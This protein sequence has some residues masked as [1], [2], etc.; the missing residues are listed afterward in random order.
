MYHH[1]FGLAVEKNTAWDLFFE[2]KKT[3]IDV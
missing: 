1:K 2:D 3:A